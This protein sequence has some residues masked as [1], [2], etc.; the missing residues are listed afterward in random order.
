MSIAKCA[1]PAACRHGANFLFL[2]GGGLCSSWAG[3][4]EKVKIDVYGL[5]LEGVVVESS[6]PDPCSDD[7]PAIPPELS[8]VQVDLYDVSGPS[9]LP[10]AI[11]AKR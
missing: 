2:L 8:V 5:N 10:G 4:K 6:T 9:C 11:Q 1:L 7:W 3:V